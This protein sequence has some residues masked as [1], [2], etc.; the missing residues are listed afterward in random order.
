MWRGGGLLV[1]IMNNI[2]Y[3]R[4]CDLERNDIEVIWLELIINRE[5]TLISFT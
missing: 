3:T 4:R 5:K 1:Y 2:D